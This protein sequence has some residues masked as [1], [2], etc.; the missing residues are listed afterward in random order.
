ML[1][2]LFRTMRGDLEVRHR[3]GFGFSSAFPAPTEQ[4]KRH[5]AHVGVVWEGENVRG[6]KRS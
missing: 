1:D 5:V 6:L 3:R 2:E 4:E